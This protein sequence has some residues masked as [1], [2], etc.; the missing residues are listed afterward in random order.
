MTADTLKRLASQLRRTDTVLR[1]LAIRLDLSEADKAALLKAAAV[2]AVS[3]QKVAAKAAI[4]KRDEATR[5]KAIANATQ[6][7]KRLLADWKAASTLDKA[8]LCICNRTEDRLRRIIETR[9]EDPS[10]DLAYWFEEAQR[11]IPASAAWHAVTQKIPVSQPMRKARERNE[12][13]RVHEATAVLAVRL[14]ALI[15]APARKRS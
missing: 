5:E 15:D 7:A 13:C 4:S 6:E 10:G 12:Q 14:Q 8:A 2:L 11:E 1:H 3:G 9:S